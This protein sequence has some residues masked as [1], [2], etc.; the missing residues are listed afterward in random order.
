[1]RETK[2]QRIIRL[3]TSQQWESR[4]SL[5]RAVGASRELVRRVVN[6]ATLEVK[7]GHQA[8][9]CNFSD[10]WGDREREVVTTRYT[11]IGAYCKPHA[12][13]Q[14]NQHYDAFWLM[15]VGWHKRNAKAAKRR[16]T[17][18]KERREELILAQCRVND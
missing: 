16:L 17:R 7:K 15:P 18:A 11:L 5:S 4:A 6:E 9:R 10:C 13:V 8:M 12:V 2:T 14:L 1:M 3:G